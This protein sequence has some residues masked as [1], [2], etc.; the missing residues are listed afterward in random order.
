MILKSVKGGAVSLFP[1]RTVGFSKFSSN[2]I[3]ISQT[4]TEALLDGFCFIGPF[5]GPII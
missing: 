3:L 4:H 2:L 5:L 1:I